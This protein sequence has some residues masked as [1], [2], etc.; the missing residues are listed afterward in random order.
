MHTLL[1]ESHDSSRNS[2]ANSYFIT[3]LLAKLTVDLGNATTTLHS[4]A[5]IEIGKAL[6]TE[7]QHR[8]DSLHSHALRLHHVDGLA[9]QLHDSVTGLAVSNSNG[10]LLQCVSNQ[11]EQ[12]ITTHL[13]TESLNRLF[14]FAGHRL[15]ITTREFWHWKIEGGVGTLDGES[16]QGQC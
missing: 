12:S 4:N 6:S 7:Q 14:R 5:D 16:K 11:N 1:I 9:I 3:A 2:L 15:A 13:T 10:S 8:L